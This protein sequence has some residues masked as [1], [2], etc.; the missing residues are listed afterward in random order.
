VTATIEHELRA[1][2]LGRAAG[3]GGPALAEAVLEQTERLLSIAD[4]EN[5]A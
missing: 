1:L 4:R 3:P 5:G 2:H